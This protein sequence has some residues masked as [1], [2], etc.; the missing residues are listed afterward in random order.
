MTLRSVAGDSAGKCRRAST[1]DPT[2]SAVA[3]YSRMRAI[4]TSRGRTSIRFFVTIGADEVKIGRQRAVA[5]EQLDKERVREQESLFAEP[6]P[7]VVD[8]QEAALAPR[9][10]A[11]CEGGVVGR[12]QDQV[13][14]GHTVDRAQSEDQALTERLALGQSL[15]RVDRQPT[16]FDEG[17]VARQRLRVAVTNV[18]DEATAA[19]PGRE[20]L[21]A[22]PV[23]L[24]VARARARSRPVRDL[25]VLE[26]AR[27]APKAARAP[28]AS[29]SRP[30]T[31]RIES[32]SD[33]TP[34]LTRL[35]PAAR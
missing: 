6:R 28:R 17:A 1:R 34:R 14:G 26:T 32:S 12:A 7:A 15:G 5:S 8:P 25:V 31:G 33:C 19:R 20:V 11:A 4:K 22:S 35:T 2:G 18:A 27:A 3:M 13:R 23:D 10:H 9:L 30:R 29:W 16:L 24:V 21:A